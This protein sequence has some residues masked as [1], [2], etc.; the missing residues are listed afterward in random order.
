M[1][2]LNGPSLS[3]DTVPRLPLDLRIRRLQEGLLVMHGERLVELSESAGF[4]LRAIAGHRSLAQVSALLAEEYGISSDEALED[5][6][7][8]VEALHPYGMV[9]LDS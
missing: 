4:I 2:A 5:V 9:E 8:V 6:T 1:D 3:G 7:A